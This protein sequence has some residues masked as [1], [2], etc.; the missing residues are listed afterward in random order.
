M[1]IDRNKKLIKKEVGGALNF[2][3]MSLKDVKIEIDN[4]INVYGEDAT[5]ELRSESY[6][7]SDKE[8]MY[9]F[10][11]VPETDEQLAA[12]I[13]RDEQYEAEALAHRSAMYSALKQEFGE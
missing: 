5:I 2:E 4:L 9:L 7:N 11:S 13:A 1:A 3:Y 12:R 8:Y 6:S 10:V